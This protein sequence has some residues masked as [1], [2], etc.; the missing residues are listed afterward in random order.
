MGRIM[1]LPANPSRRCQKRLNPSSKRPAK[2]KVSPISPLPIPLIPAMSAGY[3]ATP[4]NMGMTHTLF[5]LLLI[6]Q[7]IN[8][9]F[10]SSEL[11]EILGMCDRIYVMSEGRITGELNREEA[12]QEKIMKRVI[13]LEQGEDK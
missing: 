4:Q 10:I 13:N 11:P 8:P 1:I 9:V 12:S 6:S 3:V 5:L 2:K 7:L